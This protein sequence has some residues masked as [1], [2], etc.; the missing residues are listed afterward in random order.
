M[1]K[2]SFVLSSN[3]GDCIYSIPTI[4]SLIKQYECDECIIH[5]QYGCPATYSKAALLDEHPWGNVQLTEGACNVLKP[6]LEHQNWVDEV[7]IE[8][9]ETKHD[10]AIFLE[11]FRDLNQ[12]LSAG[13]ISK[14]LSGLFVMKYPIRDDIAWLKAPVNKIYSDKIVVANSLR[15][16]P[17]CGISFLK[18]YADDIVF[19][20]LDSEHEFFETVLNKSV[21]YNK[22]QDFLE[23][24]GIINGCGLFIGNQTAAFAVAEALKVKRFLLQF[25]D[26]PNVIP[27][28][29]NGFILQNQE[30]AKGMLKLHWTEN[31]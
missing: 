26:A 7:I 21:K 25:R 15:Y 5:L 6:L 11:R 8:H 24:S 4:K 1:K 29:I 20:G 14:W 3:I 16:V 28:G 30:Q 13:S 27:S 9:Y 23:L 10:K 12:N 22:T 18:D 19:V 2:I 17:Q 31:K